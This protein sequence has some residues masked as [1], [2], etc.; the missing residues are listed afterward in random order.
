MNKQLL[1]LIIFISAIGLITWQYLLPE[2]AVVFALR[3]ELNIWQTKFNET[4]SL[5]MKLADLEKKYNGMASEADKV[6]KAV[7]AE[8]DISG[9]LVQ[10]KELASQ[11]GLILQDVNFSA[12]EAKK[13]QNP[14]ASAAPNIPATGQGAPGIKILTV[15]LSLNGSYASLQNFIKSIEN[16]LRIMDIMTIDFNMQKAEAG[17]LANQDF[18]I[19]LNTY[20]R[21]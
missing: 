3:D 13:N 20:F 16:N 4:Q 19:S 12:V 18:K 21:E 10:A 2:F 15:D 17:A 9:L 11:N 7:P 1:A 8:Q 6:A 14:A 5:K